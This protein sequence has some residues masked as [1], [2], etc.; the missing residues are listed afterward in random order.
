MPRFDPAALEDF[1]ARLLM[2]VG[3]PAPDADLTA[4]L[5]VK[6]DLQGY[7]GH[8]VAH[9]GSYLTR[10]NAGIL[11]VV[12]PPEVIRD[13]P[14]F[15]LIDGKLCFG[16]VVA[17]RAMSMAIEKAEQH[18]VD[19][20]LTFA[21]SGERRPGFDEILAPDER[22]RRAAERRR[23]EGVEIE[24]HEWERLVGQAEER[25][26]ALPL[27]LSSVESAGAFPS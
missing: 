25:G 26:V 1:A 20:F 13:G 22:A 11:Q 23:T 17:H 16:Q 6:A 27:P 7:P 18:G 5:L 19:D 14:A 21:K 15:A 3:L 24:N 8:G 12:E 4:S 2:A 10:I 9:I